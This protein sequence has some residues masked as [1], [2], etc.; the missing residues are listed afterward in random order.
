MLFL[1]LDLFQPIA[2]SLLRTAAVTF[3]HRSVRALTSSG[4]VRTAAI[5]ASSRGTDGF[6][7]PHLNVITRGFHALGTQHNYGTPHQLSPNGYLPL[8]SPTTTAC[9]LSQQVCGYKVKV[10]LRRRCPHCY[11][12]KRKGRWYVECKVKPRHKQMQHKPRF[13]LYSDD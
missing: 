3:L 4:H 10:S 1:V 9:V 2:M 5:A 8:L 6:Q 11:L 13:K 12:E 7:T